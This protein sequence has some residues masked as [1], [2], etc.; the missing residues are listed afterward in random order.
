MDMIRF[1]NLGIV[2]P[3]VGRS[4]SVFGFEI[5]FYGVAVAIAMAAG[6]FMAMHVAKMTG[7]DPELIFDFALWALVLSVIGARIYY[8]VF[9]WDYYKDNLLEIFN[10]RAGGLA[11]YGGVIG[12]ILTGI[13]FSR[14]RKVNALVLLDMAAPGMVLG[15]AVGRWGNFF[16]REAFGGYTNG[17]LAMQLPMDA[18]RP[19]EI[20]SAMME[21][22]SEIDKIRFIQ[23]HPT[24]LYESLW[25]LGVLLILLLVIRK[26]WKK[27]D[28]EI[29]LLYI[30][31][32][33]AGRF[34]IEALRTDQLKLGG[35]GLP[36]SRLLA[37]AAAV[38]SALILAVMLVRAGNKNIDRKGD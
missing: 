10:L 26:G 24:F 30:L 7:H 13:V 31:G 6:V 17:L 22:I 19:E 23:V 37:A 9:S 28:G 27:F 33:S 16:N 3:H 25:N 12:G 36:V 14:V 2:L 34:W 29:L 8:V 32:Y 38:V 4:F 18:V 1:P 20:T 21:N 35:T 15:Q 11:I 5:A